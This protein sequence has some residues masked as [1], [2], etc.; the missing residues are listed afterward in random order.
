M[1]VPPGAVPRMV[2]RAD[3]RSPH[4][5]ASPGGGAASLVARRCSRRR[6]N[7][8]RRSRSASMAAIFSPKLRRAM[9]RRRSALRLQDVGDVR[10]D[11]FRLFH[12]V[13]HNLHGSAM[14]AR[15]QKASQASRSKG[16]PD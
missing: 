2:E 13:D 6:L 1:W 14:P 5:P 7:G 8:A 4:E 15:L 12:A 11:G 10:V 9:S 3:S 16:S